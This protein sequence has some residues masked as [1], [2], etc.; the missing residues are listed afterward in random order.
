MKSLVL[1]F[2]LVTMLV[3]GCKRSGDLSQDERTAIKNAIHR[4]LYEMTD[5]VRTN[6]LTGWIPFLHNSSDFKWEFNGIPSSY[7]SLVVQIRREAPH[8]RS[9]TI[10]WDSV[11]VEPLSKNEAMLSA[12]YTETVIDTNGVQSILVGTDKARLVKVNDSWRFA[13]GQTIDESYGQNK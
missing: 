11:Q 6:G 3:C 13:S 8:Y 9:L 1:S 12:K 4:V 10:K 5:S 7:D 2:I